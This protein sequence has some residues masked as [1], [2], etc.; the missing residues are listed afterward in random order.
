MLPVT[1]I[2]IRPSPSRT[3][4]STP[5]HGKDRGPGRRTPP[6]TGGSGPP[7]ADS[8]HHARPREE[9]ALGRGG[10]DPDPH[11]PVLRSDRPTVPPS[12]RLERVPANRRRAPQEVVVEEALQVSRSIGTP[13]GS[14]LAEERL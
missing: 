3:S 1:R 4:R 8:V 9:P 10:G 13:R 11:V 14:R 7:A 2:L 6:T 5:G 12:H